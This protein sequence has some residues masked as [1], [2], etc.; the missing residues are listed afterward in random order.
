MKLTGKKQNTENRR[1]APFFDEFKRQMGRN[2]NWLPGS[3]TEQWIK[4]FWELLLREHANRSPFSS[5]FVFETLRENC[6]VVDERTAFDSGRSINACIQ[7]FDQ[8]MLNKLWS[9]MAPNVQMIWNSFLWVF[10]C[11]YGYAWL[12]CVHMSATFLRWPSDSLFQC[13]EFRT[14]FNC[15]S[16]FPFLFA[17]C[18]FLHYWSHPH[19]VET[20]EYVFLLSHVCM[21]FY[22]HIYTCNEMKKTKNSKHK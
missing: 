14:I 15:R 9:N 1:I 20:C 7:F 16:E 2:P 5:K 21:N 10:V 19:T 18:V 3:L 13:F 12:S 4:V 17:C 22:T 11:F 6:F 8:T